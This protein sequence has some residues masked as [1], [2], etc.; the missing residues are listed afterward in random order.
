VRS[1][2]PPVNRPKELSGR[3]LEALIWGANERERSILHPGLRRDGPRSLPATLSS[4][5]LCLVQL[6]RPRL[7]VLLDFGQCVIHPKHQD[8]NFAINTYEQR[9]QHQFKQTK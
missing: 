8:K 3:Y 5:W 7:R 2:A 6:L 9:S 1:R 4:L